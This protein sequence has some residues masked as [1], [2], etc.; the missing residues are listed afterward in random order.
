MVQGIGS[1]RG[2]L[3]HGPATGCQLPPYLANDRPILP[4]AALSSQLQPCSANCSL[5]Q[6]TAALFSQLQPCSANCSL[7][8][9][10]A[11]LFSQ[12]QPYLNHTPGPGRGTGQFLKLPP[13]LKLTN[14]CQ[15]ADRSWTRPLSSEY[16]GTSLIRNSH[17]LGPYLA[18]KKTSPP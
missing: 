8:Q 3:S 13:F 14:T 11:A 2:V 15:L 18:H 5:I 6:P 4:T 10:T 16:R 17:P 7:I 1:T 12:L 9:P